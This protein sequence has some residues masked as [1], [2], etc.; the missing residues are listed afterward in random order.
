MRLGEP[1]GG[2]LVDRRV[3]GR[4]KDRLLEEAREMPRIVGDERVLSDCWQIA[5]GSFSPL[6]G[7]LLRED[8]ISV[9]EHARLTN[10]LVWSFPIVLPVVP[11][12]AKDISEGDDIA[13][14]L[15][16]I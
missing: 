6:E 2:R 14:S 10:G 1:H 9:V 4:K 13:L 5:I 8:Y 3:Q 7:F 15:I 12:F 11:E 16:H